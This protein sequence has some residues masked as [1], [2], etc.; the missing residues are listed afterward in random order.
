MRISRTEFYPTHAGSSSA[1][2]ESA[3]G[4]QVEVHNKSGSNQ[5]TVGIVG[6]ADNVNSVALGSG[7]GDS[8]GGYFTAIKSSGALG[9]ATGLFS[10][11]A[12]YLDTQ[13]AIGA[14]IRAANET[15]T[16]CVY[17]PNGASQ[18]TGV[19]INSNVGA[20]PEA[21]NGLAVGVS[22]G[23]DATRNWV[24]GLGFLHN[25]CQNASISDDSNSLSSIRLNG[26][27]SYGLDTVG[28][29]FTS[30]PIRLGNQQPIIARNAANT[31]ELVIIRLNSANQVSIEQ[32][33]TVPNILGT[34]TNSNAGAQCVGEVVESSV[35]SGSGITLTTGVDT[36][37]TSISLGAGD[38][39][40]FGMVGVL[41]ATGT[42]INVF[43]GA[44]SITSAN[45]NI[46]SNAFV[47]WYPSAMPLGAANIRF[48]LPQARYSLAATT[49]V[50]LIAN[51]GFIGAAM[52][53]FGRIT[54]R[55][56]R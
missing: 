30:A 35:A 48:A 43:A 46:E 23:G 16:D 53:A 54:A 40:V 2:Q 50:Y 56:R 22:S 9:A 10:I 31:N 44:S 19:W 27:H 26:S 55:R 12:R 36:N 33:L 15:T 3:C 8:C 29:I 14:E 25:S 39:D 41:G 47:N 51:S 18:G 6:M 32:T 28:G 20:T 49:T 1:D 34:L 7:A 45:A 52:K 17:N 37:V 21:R 38:W 4:L 42:K 5:Q 24:V 11:A 13:Y